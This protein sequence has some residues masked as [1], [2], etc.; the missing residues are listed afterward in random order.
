MPTLRSS[1]N[2]V[3]VPQAT[4]GSS[5]ST[6]TT[7]GSNSATGLPPPDP[8]RI[9]HHYTPADQIRRHKECIESGEWPEHNINREAIIKYYE[10]GGRCPQDKEELWAINGQLYWGIKRRP[11]DFPN[12][13]YWDKT[14]KL[15]EVSQSFQL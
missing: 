1:G 9:T 7:G 8:V 3:Q 6:A 14:P 12:G 4:T 13:S 15:C 2:P 11:D 5:S 10:D